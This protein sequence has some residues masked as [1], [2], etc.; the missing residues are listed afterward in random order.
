MF[1]VFE[2]SPP[3]SLVPFE[4]ATVAATN[5]LLQKE[6]VLARD[7]MLQAPGLLSLAEMQKSISTHSLP[8]QINLLTH[9]LISTFY[10]RECKPFSLF[11][12]VGN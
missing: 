7:K 1:S 8:L 2:L 12:S 5:R 9:S 4:L 6:H 3:H 11:N 10:G